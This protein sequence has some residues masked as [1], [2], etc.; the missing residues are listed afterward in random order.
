MYKFSHYCLQWN[1][2]PTQAN[3]K[4][5]IE[6]LTQY[7]YTGIGY[8]SVNTAS[9]VVSSILKPENGTSFGEDPLVCRLLKGIFNPRPSL[10]RYTTTWDVS[11][12]FK[13]IK[14]LPSLDECDLNNL[15]YRLAILLCQTTGQRDQ[16]ISYMNLDLMKFETDKV[17]IFVPELLKQTHPGHHLE[18]MVL[19]RH[20]DTDICALSHLEKYREVTKSIRKSNKLLLSFVKPHKPISTSTLSRWCVSTCVSTVWITFNPV[21][22]NL[23]LPA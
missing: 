5:G 11:I 16:K 18:S 9:S 3:F 14:S 8:S 19:M 21:S 17:T 10:P 2:S 1:I 12:C 15:S 23:T 6:C 22:L 4:I 13:Y 7:F 20:S